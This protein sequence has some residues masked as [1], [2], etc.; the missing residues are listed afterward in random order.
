MLSGQDLE[1]LGSILFGIDPIMA[2]GLSSV[3]CGALGWLLGPFAGGAVF[4]LWYRRL[5]PEIALV[6]IIFCTSQDFC[7]SSNTL[8]AELLVSL[9]RPRGGGVPVGGR[10]FY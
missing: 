7:K 10:G 9:L 3:G 8:R 1:K 2:M 4:G 5:A 6:R